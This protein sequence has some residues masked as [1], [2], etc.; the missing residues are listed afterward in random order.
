[1]ITAPH[2]PALMTL[3]DAGLRTYGWSEREIGDALGPRMLGA[4]LA[5]IAVGGL[6]GSWMIKR[7][8]GG[9]VRAAVSASIPSRWRTPRYRIHLEFVLYPR[10][11]IE[12]LAK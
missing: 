12:A 7:R 11:T 9:N 1:M 3:P 2:S 5:G 8:K 4:S 10:E 6:L